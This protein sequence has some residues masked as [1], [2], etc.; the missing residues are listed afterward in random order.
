LQ[1]KQ[2]TA[3]ECAAS[4]QELGGPGAQPVVVEGAAHQL[5]RRAKLFAGQGRRHDVPHPVESG[6]R[7]LTE[8]VRPRQDGEFEGPVGFQVVDERRAAPDVGLLELGRGPL[9]DDRP[10]IR[11]RRIDRVVAAGPLEHGVAG[12]PHAAAA[13]IGGRAA[14]LVGGFQHG[15]REPFPGSG[16]R[17]GDAATGTGDDHVDGLIEGCD[18]HP[19][20]RGPRR[21]GWD[22]LLGKCW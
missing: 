1:P 8:V 22:R 15:H 9:A 16:V 10:E 11:Q 19:L 21:P 6:A 17:A 20:H 3:D 4:D 12:E 2:K 18:G 7:R 14:E 13:G 5:R